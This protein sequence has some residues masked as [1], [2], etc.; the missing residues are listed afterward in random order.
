MLK[1]FNVN[2]ACTPARHYMVDLEPR[3]KAI[4]AMVD[5]GEYFTINKARQYGKTTT[6]RALTDFLKNELLRL[7]DRND[8]DVR[9]AEMFNCFS[10]W[11]EQ[12]LKPMVLIIDEVDTA[13]NNQVFLDFLA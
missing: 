13:T 11:C 1:V 4:K 6:L 5:D 8:K 7:A 12:S 2:G 3:L 10:V 9:M